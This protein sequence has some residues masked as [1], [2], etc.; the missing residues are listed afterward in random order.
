MIDST[1]AREFE[2]ELQDFLSIEWADEIISVDSFSSMG[3][4]SSNRGLVITLDN[5]AQFQLTIVQSSEVKDE[6]EL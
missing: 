4:L 1:S 5:G 2:D 3:I 6:D